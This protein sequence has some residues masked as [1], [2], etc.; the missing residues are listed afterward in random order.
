MNEINKLSIE[1]SILIL[2]NI[3]KGQLWDDNIVEQ[4]NQ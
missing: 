4:S 2:C 1:L 3:Q